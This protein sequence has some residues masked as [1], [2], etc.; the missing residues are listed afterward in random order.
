MPDVER[1]WEALQ[2]RDRKQ[3]GQFLLGV[4]SPGV[5]CVPGCKSRPLLRRNVR[6]YERRAEAE[7]DGLRACRRCRSSL[8]QYNKTASR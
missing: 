6:F 8:V 2:K 3:K 4:I 7:R 1:R 5:Y